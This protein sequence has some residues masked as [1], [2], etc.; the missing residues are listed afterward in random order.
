MFDAEGNSKNGLF[1]GKC[2]QSGS[3]LKQ[4]TRDTL[5]PIGGKMHHINYSQNFMAMLGKRRKLWEEQQRKKDSVSVS[6]SSSKF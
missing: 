4:K 2:P 5:F 3:A 1:S 6:H